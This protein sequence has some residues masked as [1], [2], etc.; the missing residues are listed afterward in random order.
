MMNEAKYSLKDFRV[1]QEVK[2]YTTDSPFETVKE[3]SGIVKEI[4]DD[5]MIVDIDGLSDHCWFEPGFNLHQLIPVPL[6]ENKVLAEKIWDQFYAAYEYSDEDHDQIVDQLYFELDSYGES[7][8]MMRTVLED[9]VN[10]DKLPIYKDD[11][12]KMDDVPDV[13]HIKLE[14]YHLNNDE[15]FKLQSM[16]RALNGTIEVKQ[17]EFT[18]HVYVDMKCD[19]ASVARLERRKGGRKRKKVVAIDENGNKVLDE[20][21]KNTFYMSLVEVEHMIEKQ[22]AIEVA[23]KL[24]MSRATLFRKLKNARDKGDDVIE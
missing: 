9:I 6:D 14:L 5:F 18:K 23:K 8:F 21:G 24:N 17:D 22:G 3:L 13:E 1:G 10:C 16:T 19:M 11:M 4:Q 2:Y 15:Y 7:A 12:I 20:D